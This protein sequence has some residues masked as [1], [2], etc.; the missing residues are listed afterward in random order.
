MTLSSLSFVVFL[1]PYQGSKSL[2]I[3][4]LGEYVGKLIF[5]AY[6]FNANVP[7]LLMVSYEVMVDMYM[8]CS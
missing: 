8:L 7:F 3:K 4:W 1:D 5:D 6:T 2:L